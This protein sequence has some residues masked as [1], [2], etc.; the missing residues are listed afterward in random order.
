MPDDN[1]NSGWNFEVKTVLFVKPTVIAVSSLKKQIVQLE[2][3][4]T[5]VIIELFSRSWVANGC[6]LPVIR[7]PGTK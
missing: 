4:S 5:V 2:Y 1:A 7:N 3:S 6:V